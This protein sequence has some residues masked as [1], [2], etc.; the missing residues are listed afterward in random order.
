MIFNNLQVAEGLALVAVATRNK[1]KLVTELTDQ[2]SLK[3]F[4][5]I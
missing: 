4:S 5:F 2:K 1:E 3:F